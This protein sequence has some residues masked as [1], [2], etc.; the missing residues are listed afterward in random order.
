MYGLQEGCLHL[1]EAVLHE[2][3]EYLSISACESKADV[4]RC[5]MHVKVALM[6]E[7]VGS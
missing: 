2:K 3:F 7:V 1:K 5:N 6:K 4:Q